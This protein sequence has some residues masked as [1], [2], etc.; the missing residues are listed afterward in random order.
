MFT[1]LRAQRYIVCYDISDDRRRSTLSRLLTGYGVRVQWSMFE[2]VLNDLEIRRLVA[3]IDRVI[4]ERD[5]VL[6][7]Q[8]AATGTPS[9][10]RLAQ[11]VDGRHDFWVS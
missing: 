5:N 6:I 1:S 8:C 9:H 3:A 11:Y 2:C 4:D 7:N 10:P